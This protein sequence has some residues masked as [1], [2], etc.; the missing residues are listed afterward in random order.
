MR[1]N[2]IHN[3]ESISTLSTKATLDGR[4]LLIKMKLDKNFFSRSLCHQF[5]RMTYKNW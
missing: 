1:Y 5:S 3:V 2:V 4:D